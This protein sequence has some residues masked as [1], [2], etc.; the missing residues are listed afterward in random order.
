[1]W[2]EGLS[3]FSW[4]LGR[5]IDGDGGVGKGRVA[6]ES[7]EGVMTFFYE[8]SGLVGVGGLL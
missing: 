7:W 8:D 6:L 2:G 4:M 1:M 5:L 3:L